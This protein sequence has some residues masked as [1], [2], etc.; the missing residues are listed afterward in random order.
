MRRRVRTTKLNGPHSSSWL[1]G[2]TMDVFYGDTGALFEKWAKEYGPVYQIPAA[3]GEK[4]TVLTDPRAIAHFYSKETYTYVNSDFSKQM[5]DNII[6]KG[7]L[8]AEGDSHR[9]Q[10]RTLSPAF[11]NAAIRT[12][13]PVFFDSGY[14]VKAAWDSIIASSG[15]EETVIDVQKWMNCVSLDSIGIAG[16]G[17]DFG[18]LYG[19]H[20]TIEEVFDAFGTRPPAGLMVLT[21]LLGPALPILTKLPGKRA[22]LVSKLHKTMQEVSEA[23][24]ERS[25][26]EK[27]LAGISSDTS[28]SIIGSLLR[29]EDS[30]S[31]LRLTEEEVLAQMRVLLVAGYETTSISLTWAL[32]ELSLHPDKQDKLREELSEF[33]NRDPTYDQLMN[34]LPYLDAVA[35]EVIRLHPPVEQ[36]GRIATCDDVVPLSVPITTATG[37]RVDHITLARDTSIIVP[38]RAINRSEEIWG[39]DAKE[40]KPERWLNSESGLTEKAKEIHGYHHILSFIDGPRTCLGRPFAIAEFKSVLSVLIRNYAFGLRDG[41]DT[42]IDLVTSILP[43]PKVVG[44]EGYAMPM[45]VRRFEL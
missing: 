5:I 41:P 13:T 44:E 1:F 9:R 36:T 14:K 22:S 8:W 21:I 39:P 33:A 4:T 25:R 31:D 17:H 27:E 32:I 20:S 10:R 2:V 12:L 38:I 42:K 26:K 34:S 24:L 28:R 29:A 15:S 6:G 7:L 19:R 23:L 37:E 16:F 30:T 43:R 18:A 45:R 35:R 11:T 3:L 40:F